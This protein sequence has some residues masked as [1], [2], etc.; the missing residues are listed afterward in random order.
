M[1]IDE[2]L[3]LAGGFGTRLQ[4]VVS[5]IPKPMADIEGRPF[6]AYLLQFLS[7]QGCR[8]CVLSTGYKH[9]TIS[10]YFGKQYRGMSLDYA[11]ENEPLGTGGGIKNGLKFLDGTD[12]FVLNGD[13]FF[14]VDLKK[15]Q[16]YHFENKAAITLSLKKM[17]NVDR[18]GTVET[19]NGRATG[20]NEKKF[21]EEG[22][23]NGGVYAVSKSVFE[24]PSLGKKFSFEK[25]ILEKNV[26][27]CSVF[28]LDFDGYFIDIGIPEDYKKAQKELKNR[29]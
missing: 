9:E 8:R 25:D 21:V 16:D 15:L 29:F 10:D 22:Y 17:F 14:D 13:S 3:I 27:E 4:P 24:N 18:Y 5:D 11:I 2:A 7:A 12:F 23:I 20:F 6:L 1:K 26:K 28:A 19:E